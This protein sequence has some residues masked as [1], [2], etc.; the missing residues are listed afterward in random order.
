MRWGI[1]AAVSEAPVSE[2]PVSEM[3]VPEAPVTVSPLRRRWIVGVMLFWMWSMGTVARAPMAIALLALALT[4]LCTF[5]RKRPYVRRSDEIRARWRGLRRRPDYYLPGGL[6]LAYVIALA[7]VDDWDFLQTRI[8][9]SAQAL[10]IPLI[11]YVLHPTVSRYRERLWLGFG[12]FAAVLGA[13]ATGYVLLNFDAFLVALG[14][15]RSVPTAV[16]H[17]RTGMIL[18]VAAVAMCYQAVGS[19]AGLVRLPRWHALAS[20]VLAVLLVGSIHVVVIRTALVMF[21]VGAGVLLLR[22]VLTRLSWRQ[23][24]VA[25][26][27]VAGGIGLVA[28]GSPTLVR[29]AR[30]TVYDIGK[31][32]Q[33]DAADY[34]DGGRV[35]SQEAALRILREDPWW[36]AAPEGLRVRQRET[37]AEMGVA[38]VPHLPHNQW[39][40]S[41]A[42]VGAVG[43]I[44]V[45]CVVFAPAFR[46]N[47]LREPLVAEAVAMVAALT[48]AD[49]CLESDVGVGVAVLG[50]WL[51][52]ARG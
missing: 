15:S 9:L 40:F 4:A 50:V 21:Y 22:L 31:L 47:W 17:V 30:M 45:G 32:G 42:A 46:Q 3:L 1:F 14:K 39:L 29:K 23:S 33:A 48:L 25:V 10:G 19:W 5:S 41:W 28:Y 8:Q 38:E 13:A 11:L 52:K 2:M 24:A 20:A 44:G 12:V 26:A 34:S 27:L 7:Y 18:A 16:G 43:A 51:G 37:Y 49:A 35:L 36:G 6:L